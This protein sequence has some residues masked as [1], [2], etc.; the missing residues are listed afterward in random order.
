MGRLSN[1]HEA[2]Q[3]VSGRGGRVPVLHLHDTLYPV[4]SVNFKSRE[5]EA[6]TLF[7]LQGVCSTSQCLGKIKCQPAPNPTPSTSTL[8]QL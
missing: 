5:D 4:F 2:T 3:L 7:P 1:W 6:T 8:T